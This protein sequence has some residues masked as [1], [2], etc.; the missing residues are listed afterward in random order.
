M[1]DVD[2]NNAVIEFLLQCP[3]IEGDPLYFNYINAKN[4]AK[5]IMTVANDVALNKR[6]VDGSVLKRFL[7]TLI[8]FKTISDT[9]LLVNY[10]A[11]ATNE[12]VEEMAAVQKVVDWI[13]EQ[14]DNHNFPNFGEN[15]LIQT[16]GTT[17]ENPTL[18]GVNPDAQLAM[19]SI[20]IQIDYIDLSKKIWR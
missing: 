1:A 4:D 18:D 9:A 13:H 6:Y 14:N 16:M 3:Y 19:Y 7:F 2:K 11:G 10:M 8:D 12:N 5:Q 15:C 20:T 17:T